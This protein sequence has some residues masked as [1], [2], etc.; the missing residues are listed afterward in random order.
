[1]CAS[2]RRALNPLLFL[3]HFFL[4][5]APIVSHICEYAC[6]QEMRSCETLGTSQPTLS[7]A[8]PQEALQVLPVCAVLC[9]DTFRRAY[10]ISSKSL[11]PSSGITH[12]DESLL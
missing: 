6:L 4:C 8:P 12:R 5:S 9:P 10:A 2:E 7:C 11:C 1:M 3:P